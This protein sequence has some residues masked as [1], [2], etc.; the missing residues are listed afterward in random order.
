MIR[1]NWDQNLAV[2]SDKRKKRKLTIR[3]QWYFLNTIL[4]IFDHQLEIWCDLPQ[5]VKR[6][7]EFLMVRWSTRTD[8]LRLQT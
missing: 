3:R 7:L 5:Q 8:W 4:D 6:R 2:S 1:A